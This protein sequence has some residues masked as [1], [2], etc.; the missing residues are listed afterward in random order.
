MGTN[1][2]LLNTHLL[3]LLFAIKSWTAASCIDNY[4]LAAFAIFCQNS[5]L[6]TIHLTS[7]CPRLWR[8]PIA[9]FWRLWFWWLVFSISLQLLA[10]CQIQDNLLRRLIKNKKVNKIRINSPNYITHISSPQ[11]PAPI[12]PGSIPSNSKIFVQH[13]LPIFGCNLQNSTSQIYS[14]SLNS[15]KV[16]SL[17]GY[18]IAFFCLMQNS[19]PIIPSIQITSHL[20]LLLS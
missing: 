18:R 12:K 5:P 16:N 20:F 10:F 9:L 1:N 6:S 14:E 4:R 7:N 8:C 17:F 15:N 3:T 2:F 19:F 11:I 13:I